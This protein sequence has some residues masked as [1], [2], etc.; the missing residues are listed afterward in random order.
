MF[1]CI[2][3]NQLDYNSNIDVCLSSNHELWNLFIIKVWVVRPIYHQ[4]MSCGTYLSSKH[5]LWDLFIIK[6]WVVGPIYHKAWVVEPIYHQSMSCET[7][8]SS[9]HE[10]WDLFIVKAWVVEPIYHQSMSCETYLSS[11]HE[12]WDLLYSFLPPS[13]FTVCFVYLLFECKPKWWIVPSICYKT[14][15]A[16]LLFV[17]I[18]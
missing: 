10:L 4:S 5:E 8:L 17:Y 16:R 18:E 11:K 13:H 9:K 3:F 1:V 7:Y 6:V 2:N 15:C 12:L 14:Q